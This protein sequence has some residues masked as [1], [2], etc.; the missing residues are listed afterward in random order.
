MYDEVDSN[1]LDK[2]VRFVI[3]LL[4]LVFDPMAVLL[5]IAA[6][7]SIRQL[8]EEKEEEIM[9]GATTLGPIPMNKDELG[10]VTTVD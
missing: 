10:R 3:I 8:N 1:V 4:V 2:S 6:N 7:F 5:V 9:F